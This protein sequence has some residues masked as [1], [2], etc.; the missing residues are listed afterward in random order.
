MCLF[1]KKLILSI[2]LLLFTGMLCVGGYLTLKGYTY[3]KDALGEKSLEEMALEI[4]SIDH[5]TTIDELPEI[6][7]NAVISVEDQRFYDHGGIDLLAIARA[8]YHD[9]L[10][11]SFVEGGST[12]TQQ[13][14]KNQYFSQEKDITR[15]IAEVFMAFDIEKAFTKDEILEL[16]LN[17][18]YFG[19]GYYCV[20]DACEGYFGKEPS[21]MND[22]EATLLAG[23]PNAPSVYAPTV[24][25]QLARQRQQQVIQQMIDC[26]YIEP[27][28]RLQCAGRPELGA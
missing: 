18:I 27:T 20:A 7:K 25:P 23:V 16:Y 22:D 28:S 21:E 26:G 3:Y 4:R 1:M 2:A 11:G 15:K 14:A 5:Y 24:N 10:A 12:I 6:Y 9:I 13:L 17:S 8:L 19:D